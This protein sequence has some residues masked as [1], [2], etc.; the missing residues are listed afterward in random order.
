MCPSRPSSAMLPVDY[1]SV[2]FDDAFT[3]HELR[4]RLLAIYVMRGDPGWTHRTC[5]ACSV[6][7]AD[8][9]CG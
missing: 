1:D 3:S 2:T 6:L 5:A 9:Y 7:A 8:M 4:A